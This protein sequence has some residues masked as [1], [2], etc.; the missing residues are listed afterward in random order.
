MARP[1]ALARV[2]GTAHKLGCLTD[3]CLCCAAPA[4][5]SL[6]SLAH[7]DDMPL[8]CAPPAPQK[9]WLQPKHVHAS[10]RC[11]HT[12]VNLVLVIG[13]VGCC[14]LVL[15]R[16]LPVLF[17]VRLR[18]FA[19]RLCQPGT[20][21][22]LLVCCLECF[23]EFAGNHG[24]GRCIPGLPLCAVRPVRLVVVAARVDFA[25]MQCNMCQCVESCCALAAGL[26][27]AHRGISVGNLYRGLLA[28]CVRLATCVTKPVDSLSTNEMR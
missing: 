11:R 17:L 26:L 8:N 6:M 20:I 16:Y 19:S 14:L 18:V 3:L 28:S 10:R 4:T 23:P 2:L 27:A 7:A 1:V 12:L 5:S 25:Y 9:G 22:R 21:Q 24:A 15:A 13:W